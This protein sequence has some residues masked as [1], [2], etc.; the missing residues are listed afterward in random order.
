[1]KQ[2]QKPNRN[3]DSAKGTPVDTSKLSS[4]DRESLQQLFEVFGNGEEYDWALDAQEMEDEG[5]EMVL[6][7]H[8]RRLE[9]AE[10]KGAYV[11]RGRQHY[12]NCRY[13]R[14]L[15]SI[16]VELELC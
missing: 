2:R 13:S 15:P 5:A 10:L 3:K 14:A 8:G 11:D 4:V 1:M 6:T 7:P 9:H 12:T 16:P